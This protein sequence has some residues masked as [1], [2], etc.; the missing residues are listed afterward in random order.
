LGGIKLKILVFQ[1]KSNLKAHLDWEKKMVFVFNC[2]RKREVKLAMIE[3][4][5]YAIS[6]WDQIVISRRRNGE[7]PL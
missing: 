3:F 4:T 6:W 7:R 1:G 5:N 2:H